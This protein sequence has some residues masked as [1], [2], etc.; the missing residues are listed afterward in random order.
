MAIE[1]RNP[2]AVSVL[3]SLNGAEN[4]VCQVTMTCFNTDNGRSVPF[5]ISWGMDDF[6]PTSDFVNFQD[7]TDENLI[8][9]AKSGAGSDM[10][11]DL[12]SQVM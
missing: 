10:I 8:T 4:V 3:P 9:W 1:Y 11:A 12:E 2:S 6:S 5:T 7:V